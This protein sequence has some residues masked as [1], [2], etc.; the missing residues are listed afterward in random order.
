MAARKNPQRDWEKTRAR[1]GLLLNRMM[2]FAECDVSDPANSAKL[3]TKT[4]VAASVAILKK[5]MPDLKSIEL[6]NPEGEQLAVTHIV[7]QIIDAPSASDREG[8]PAPTDAG[9]L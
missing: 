6:R 7:R 1:A 4:Q 3:M 2:T 8:V 9:P 5:L